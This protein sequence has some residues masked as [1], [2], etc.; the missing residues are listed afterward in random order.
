MWVERRE[1]GRKGER[2]GGG[3]YRRREKPMNVR[4]RV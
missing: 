2:G 4:R 1:A 3:G